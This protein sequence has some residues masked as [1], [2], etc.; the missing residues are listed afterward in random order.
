MTFII[1]KI[2]QNVY[3]NSSQI[4]YVQS[5]ILHLNF[6]AIEND[7]ESDKFKQIRRYVIFLYKVWSFKVLRASSVRTYFRCIAHI[8]I[9]QIH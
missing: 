7:I 5:H 1:V 4:I 8:R 2:C 9:H 6:I 3:H